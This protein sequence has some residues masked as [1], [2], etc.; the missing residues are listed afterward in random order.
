LSALAPTVELGCAWPPLG[1]SAINPFE[2][3]LLNTVILLS[4]GV[5]VTWAHHS[6]IEGNRKGALYGTLATIVL[7]II[8]TGALW[9]RKLQ[10]SACIK[11]PNS[12][13]ILK[14][15]IPNYSFK[16]TIINNILRVIIQKIL[17]RLY[18]KG[19]KKGMD[20]RGSKSVPNIINYTG[21]AIINNNVLGI[22][23]EQRVDGNWLL[24]K[25]A[26]TCRSLRCTLMGSVSSYPIRILSKE[27]Y[28][29]TLHY[30]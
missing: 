24:N 10:I 5:T 22:V 15:L 11:L 1:I 26:A 21:T 19:A 14:L 18:K 17:V 28:K 3:P 29:S 12:G 27:L 30:L 8:F 25:Q 2:L 6:L 23:K 4:S 13:E 16:S 9:I 20:N 7:A